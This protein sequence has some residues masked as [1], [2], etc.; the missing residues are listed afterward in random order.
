M[1][2]YL[3]LLAF[4][5]ALDEVDNSLIHFGPPEVSSVELDGL[6]MLHVARYLCIVLGL[7]YPLHDFLQDP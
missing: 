4:G 5:T 3:I 7:N 2:G 6:V 1:P